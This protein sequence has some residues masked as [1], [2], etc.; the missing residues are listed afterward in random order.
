MDLELKN[1]VST[2]QSVTLGLVQ[3]AGKQRMKRA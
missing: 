2:P 1:F 3:A